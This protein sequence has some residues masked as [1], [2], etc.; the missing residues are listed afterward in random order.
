MNIPLIKYW[1]S[2]SRLGTRWVDVVA[3]ESGGVSKSE[4]V[5]NLTLSLP[6][7]TFVLC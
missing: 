4:N 6:A 3:G 2:T 5:P 7:A 1:L